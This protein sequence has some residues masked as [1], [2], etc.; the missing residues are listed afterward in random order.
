MPIQVTPVGDINSDTENVPTQSAGGSALT[1][2]DEGVVLDS[3]VTSINFVGTPITATN[4]GHAVTVTVATAPST[5]GGATRWDWIFGDGIDGSATCDGVAAVTGMSLAAGKYTLTRSVAFVNLTIS[6]G[7]T[8]Y[9]NNF[10]PIF[11]NGTLTSAGT[12][13]SGNSALDGSG[14]TPGVASAANFWAAGAVGGSPGFSD[15]GAISSAG[16]GGTGGIGGASTGGPGTGGGLRGG[17]IVTG[18]AVNMGSLAFAATLVAGVTGR[19][20]DSTTRY[21]GGSGGG[22]GDAATGGGGGAGGQCGMVAA[23]NIAGAGTFTAKG[24]NGGNAASGNAGGGAGGGG[25]ALWLFTQ[26]LAPTGVWTISAA[27]GTGGTPTGTGKSGVS[28]TAGR[29]YIYV[30][31]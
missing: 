15:G 29:T 24:G 20:A 9:L 10:G 26:T 13:H 5:S 27:A 2:K 3:A 17:G 31:D 1:V 28:G 18:P 14:S 16:I 19:T 6:A 12:I 22:G 4:V 7:V 23:R 30:A 11:V 21:G 8:V 25:G